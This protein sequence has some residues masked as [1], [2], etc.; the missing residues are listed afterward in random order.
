MQHPRCTTCARGV[1]MLLVMS[2]P[3]L[4]RPFITSH[5]PRHAHY[6]LQVVLPSV[7]ASSL[8]LHVHLEAFDLHFVPA[9]WWDSAQ[10]KPHPVGLHGSKSIIVTIYNK[11]LF[12]LTPLSCSARF[13]HIDTLISCFL[14]Y[15]TIK[16]ALKR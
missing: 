11:L 14:H 1:R 6:C 13:H 9:D 3:S 15:D 12:V 10:L 7:K 5:E 4:K 2:S 8:M 16:A